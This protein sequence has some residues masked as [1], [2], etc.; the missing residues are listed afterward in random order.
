M[1]KSSK[2]PP[3]LGQRCQTPPFF[4]ICGDFS[5]WLLILP[6]MWWF[7]ATYSTTHN[8]SLMGGSEFLNKT[9]PNEMQVFY[10]LH[11]SHVHNWLEKKKKIP[12]NIDKETKVVTYPQKLDLKVHSMNLRKLQFPP[13]YHKFYE[14][15]QFSPLLHLNG[16]IPP[17]T[18]LC[19]VS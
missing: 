3:Q 5:T 2:T 8:T 14:F 6:Q 17:L 7:F 13:T 1:R 15:S 9:A 16:L 11:N 4:A 18:Y 10:Q 19:T 12:T